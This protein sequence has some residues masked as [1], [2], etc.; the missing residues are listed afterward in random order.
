[1]GGERSAQPLQ[2]AVAA[3]GSRRASASHV[4]RR[5]RTNASAVSMTWPLKTGS[6]TS[7]KLTPQKLAR[8][9]IRFVG[10][11]RRA[12]RGRRSSLGSGKNIA[13]NRLM[14]TS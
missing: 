3:A 14:A 9:S 13:P 2:S 5:L 1:V 7:S 10:W 11:G 6:C 12:R 8:S 4:L